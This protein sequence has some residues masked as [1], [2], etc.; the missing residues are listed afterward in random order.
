MPLAL[1][2]NYPGARNRA[3]I[4]A[5]V[6]T[7]LAYYL[8][9]LLGFALRLPPS[10]PSVL[11]PPNAIL[12]SALLLTPTRWWP[13]CLAAALP[14]HLATQLP[15][16][17]PVTMILLLFVTNCSEA[18]I[19]AGFARWL[20]R[21]R[22]RLDRLRG[23][24]VFLAAVVVVGPLL[25]TVADA[26]V[27]HVFNGEPFWQV[28]RTRLFSNTLAE[29]TIVPAAI[30]LVTLATQRRRLLLSRLVEATIIGAGLVLT[31]VVAFSALSQLPLLQ[32]ISTE[33][34]LALPLPFLLWAAARFGPGGAGVASFLTTEFTV[35]AAV[36]NHGPFPSFGFHAQV[37]PLQ[38][39][40]TVVT[41]T[42]L[43]LSTLVAERREALRELTN[44]WR[45]ERLMSRLSGAFVRVPS[46]RMQA[47]F[48]EWTA[49]IGRAF[50]LD[51][52]VLLQAKGGRESETLS[53]WTRAS[54]ADPSH[55]VSAE[56]FPW[57]ADR[58]LAGEAILVDRSAV[59][60]ADAVTDRTSADRLGL[61]A[62]YAMPLSASGRVI[63]ALIC[64]RKSS[65][66]WREPQVT[67]LRLV[68][69]VLTNAVARKE[70]E[71][72][73]RTSESAKSALLDSLPMAV[74]V[75]DAGGRIETVNERWA[76]LGVGGHAETPPVGVRLTSRYQVLSA[77]TWQ[78]HF[79][80]MASGIQS[81]LEGSRERYLSDRPRQLSDGRWWTLLAVRLNR[82][83][84]GAVIINSD[85][86]EL[87]RAELEAQ[88]HRA[89]LAH[90]SRV[91][92]L[93]E[94]T[95]SLAHQLNQPL[96]AIMANASAA[97]MLLD[98][99]LPATAQ[100]REILTDIT[101][102]DRRASDVI[103]RLREM[104]RKRD[105]E[106]TDVDIAS[107][108]DDV[109][110]LIHSDAVI[111]RVQIETQLHD[112]PIIVR[113][114]RVQLHQVLLNLIVN[115]LEAIGADR[116]DRK[117][118]VAAHR[119]DHGTILVSVADSGSGL[120]EASAALIFDPFYTTKPS[121]L[122]MGLSIARSIV[123]AHGGSIRAT[124][125]PNGGA[126][127]EITLPSPAPAY[128]GGGGSG[129]G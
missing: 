28:S 3:V 50:R 65:G 80:D 25:S 60:P 5:A 77:A 109:T 43:T 46:N 9:S 11:W 51:V 69:N 41:L 22:L 16:G 104:L 124:S 52:V 37:L 14:A 20:T 91:S 87:R 19:G 55:L 74:A 8:G 129:L 40:L 111:R 21:G 96:T 123:E 95:T 59:L 121:G 66:K 108:I 48:D 81:V 103:Q 47:S 101:N 94:L 4:T 13:A 62:A 24:V 30:G 45:L 58:V 32:L 17:W 105:L 78:P 15:M 44:R 85:V 112:R 84:G 72:A 26:T 70:I 73:L 57:A 34:P 89:E 90:V 23:L 126:V 92:M 122:G 42:L 110:R 35:Y 82:E 119:N 33:A 75:I 6:T 127:F 93:G 86:T 128:A 64:G 88:R 79:D 106:I 63:G 68:A 31:E 38:L 107:A 53:R 117:V 99:S 12:T 125:R 116:E 118:T 1:L 36:H 29:L 56:A 10:I 120:S 83:S 113:G 49:R 2:A 114:D 71:D 115:A 100:V 76:A 67:N 97:R 98:P 102:E 7:G 18:I 61:R 54:F 27:V 39:S